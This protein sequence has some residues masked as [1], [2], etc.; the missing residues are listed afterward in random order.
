MSESREEAH[1]SVLTGA[2]RE[3]WERPG[4]RQRSRALIAATEFATKLG[5]GDD[6]HAVIL[7]RIRGLGKGEAKLAWQA[8][9]DMNETLQM[10]DIDL[11]IAE[12]EVEEITAVAAVE[13][14][15]EQQEKAVETISDWFEGRQFDLRS[16]QQFYKSIDRK[17]EEE[18]ISIP[19]TI[20]QVNSN[21]IIGL[22]ALYAANH[23]KPKVAKKQ[24]DYL[25][26]TLLVDAVREGSY[27]GGVRYAATS[28]IGELLNNDELLNDSGKRNSTES[29]SVT[30]EPETVADKMQYIAD[31]LNGLIEHEGEKTAYD[32]ERVERLLDQLHKEGID[33]NITA[34][35]FTHD[36]LRELALMYAQSN[37]NDIESIRTNIACTWGWLAG[38]EM[39]ELA[40]WRRATKPNAEAQDVHN[41]RASFING[42]IKGWKKGLRPVLDFTDELDEDTAD[43][44]E[45]VV[46]L[47]VST[48]VPTAEEDSGEKPER[49]LDDEPRNV[50]VVDA[51]VKQLGLE[52]NKRAF[53]E[54][55]N[56]HAR[57]EFTAAKQI[58]LEQIRLRVG[59]VS[60]D[61]SIINELSISPRAK[62]ALRRMLGM[63][64]V[65]HG[66]VEERTPE[67]LR[68]QLRNM[69][70][71]D[72]EGYANDLYTALE[73]LLEVIKPHNT[74]PEVELLRPETE[75]S[76]KPMQVV[77][78]DDGE[79]LLA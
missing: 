44:E 15:T 9:A 34:V 32:L 64:F 2:E 6:V 65:K 67:P 21:E 42:V 78:G 16:V 43:S 74:L 49:S 35:D 5:L 10:L 75:T 24:L 61:A 45:V 22:L 52:I 28:R 66:R 70:P 54:L 8:F 33:L 56:P 60:P 59:T 50:R 69:A 36:T 41:S 51:Y 71:F 1:L 40:D 30:T 7:E 46:D 57:G 38:I 25:R 47:P 68:E 12:T 17:T 73:A 19:E 39:A 18:W 14:E 29:E 58:V 4:L 27:G 79:A 20:D 76:V 77:F 26:E 72:H 48:A 11:D 13:H 62:S 3:A 63:G 31:A 23:S 55:L 53:E 37:G